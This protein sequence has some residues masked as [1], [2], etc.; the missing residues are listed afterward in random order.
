MLDEMVDIGTLAEYPEPTYKLESLI[1]I[2]GR[3]AN[4]FKVRLLQSDSLIRHLFAL[5]YLRIE[6]VE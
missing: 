1:G 5:D 2:R 3:G 6:P 4:V